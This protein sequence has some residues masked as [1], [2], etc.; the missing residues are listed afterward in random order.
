MNEAIQDSNVHD[1]LYETDKQVFF[2][3]KFMLQPLSQQ[4]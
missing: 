1:N 2:H 3:L 4:H